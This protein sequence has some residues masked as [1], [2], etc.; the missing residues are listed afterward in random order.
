MVVCIKTQQ[1][2][3]CLKRVSTTKETFLEML[4]ISLLTFVLVAQR[5][6]FFGP[7]ASPLSGPPFF[8][9][10]PSLPLSFSA[11]SVLS[12][13]LRCL[14]LYESQTPEQR[15][16]SPAS[17][18]LLMPALFYKWK[19]LEESGKKKSVFFSPTVELESHI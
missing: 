8:L 13:T 18:R 5:S 11:L 17:R 15:D 9:P 16:R 10:F 4:F 19:L 3:V 7:L 6:Y 14:F 12:A 1:Q 2:Q